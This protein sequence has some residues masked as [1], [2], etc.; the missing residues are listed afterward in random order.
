MMHPFKK[1]ISIAMSAPY[2]ATNGWIMVAIMAVGPIVMFSHE[3]KMTYIN[4]AINAAYSPYYKIIT[5][6]RNK[7]SILKKDIILIK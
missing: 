4:D 7:T 3:P 2:V 6:Q 1:A 5:L